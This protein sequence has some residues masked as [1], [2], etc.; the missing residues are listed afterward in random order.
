MNEDTHLR[1]C[2]ENFCSNF[3]FSSLSFS[4]QVN[5]YNNSKWFAAT[6]CVDQIK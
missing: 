2:I 6:A 3:G 1:N 5:V 4:F